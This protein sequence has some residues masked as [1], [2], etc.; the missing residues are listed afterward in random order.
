MENIIKVLLLN[1]K[2]VQVGTL[3]YTT[4]NA[5]I[6][7]YE[8]TSWSNYQWRI[9]AKKKRRI[10]FERKINKLK[11]NEKKKYFAWCLYFFFFDVTKPFWVWTLRQATS[12]MQLAG[13]PHVP[14]ATF[15]LPHVGSWPDKYRA[16]DKL[17]AVYGGK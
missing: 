13:V 6:R 15:L 2:H 8:T 4:Y 10:I 14:R 12:E 17:W 1:G 9:L 16:G 7:L 3:E 5:T 11:T